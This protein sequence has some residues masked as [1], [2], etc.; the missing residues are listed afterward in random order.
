[1]DHLLVSETLGANGNRIAQLL[2]ATHCTRVGS[3]ED[4]T[5]YILHGQAYD[6]RWIEDNADGV[7][8]DEDGFDALWAHLLDEA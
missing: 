4:H 3:T 6:F 1:M 8:E 7:G 2:N 5:A